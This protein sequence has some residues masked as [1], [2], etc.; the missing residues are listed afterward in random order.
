MVEPTLFPAPTL[1]VIEPVE[2]SV[3][4]PEDTLT[5]PVPADESADATFTAP[6]VPV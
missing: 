5:A 1:K 4:F 6:L 2:S 3:A